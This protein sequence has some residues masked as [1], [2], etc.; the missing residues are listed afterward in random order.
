MSLHGSDG[1]LQNEKHDKKEWQLASAGEILRTDA[2]PGQEAFIHQAL[3]Q[4]ED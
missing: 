1:L 4:G 2:M 3:A